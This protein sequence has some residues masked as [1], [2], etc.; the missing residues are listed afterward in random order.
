MW[1]CRLWKH[2]LSLVLL[3]F[4]FALPSMQEFELTNERFLVPEMIFHP[5][6]LG[7][8]STNIIFVW[9]TLLCFQ[10]NVGTRCFFFG[11]VKCFLDLRTCCYNCSTILS[12]TIFDISTE[13]LVLIFH[14]HSTVICMLHHYYVDNSA[15]FLASDKFTIII[16]IVLKPSYR[17]KVG[18]KVFFL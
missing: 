8:S 16:V 3:A 4:N 6:D 12:F 18:H 10:F 5:A 1:A 15:K 9:D 14:D 13:L 7:L 17:F 11:T 2:V